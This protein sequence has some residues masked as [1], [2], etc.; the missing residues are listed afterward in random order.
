MIAKKIFKS[1]KRKPSFG[2]SESFSLPKSGKIC[3]PEFWVYAFV[4]HSVY[5]QNPINKGNITIVNQVNYKYI[6]ELVIIELNG[7]KCYN[8]RTRRKRNC[9]IPIC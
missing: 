4:Y 7:N 6:K 2:L 8:A 9:N 3:K 5:P 1:Q